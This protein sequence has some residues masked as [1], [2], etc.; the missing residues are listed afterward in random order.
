MNSVIIISVGVISVIVDVVVVRGG[1]V[2]TDLTDIRVIVS[3]LQAASH[4]RQIETRKRY[5][6][7]IRHPNHCEL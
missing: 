3:T 6:L 2:G 5:F 1:R 7:I 4:R